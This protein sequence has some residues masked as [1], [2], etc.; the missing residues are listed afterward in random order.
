MGFGS[1]FKK[2]GKG[3]LAVLESPVGDILIAKYVPKEFGPLVEKA[4]EMVSALE[5]RREREQALPTPIDADP[6]EEAYRELAL[7]AERRG[8]PYTPSELNALIEDMLQE[9]KGTA[10]VR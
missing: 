2:L 3:A 4:R 6:R 1:F 9:H 8:I 10:I 7:E 5:A